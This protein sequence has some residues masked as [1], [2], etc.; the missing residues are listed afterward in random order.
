[1][2]VPLRC[3]VSLSWRYSAVSSALRDQLHC[4][5]AHPVVIPLPMKLFAPCQRRH[6]AIFVHG[7]IGHEMELLA[8]R[9]PRIRI[10]SMIEQQARKCRITLE[11]THVAVV[12]DASEKWGM[13]A[14]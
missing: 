9:C 13:P 7:F 3:M 5:F 14:K 8:K 11:S 6:I 4:R 10:S 12:H 1:M 2:I